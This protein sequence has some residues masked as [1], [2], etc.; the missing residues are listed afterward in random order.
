MNLLKK[1]PR[2]LSGSA[3]HCADSEG[4]YELGLDFLT[5][6][7]SDFLYKPVSER[8]LRIVLDRA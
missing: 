7:A 6:G 4:E 2:R 5:E 8:A 1:N 3:Y